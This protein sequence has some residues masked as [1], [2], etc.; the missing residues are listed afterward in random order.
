M[1]DIRRFTRSESSAP[2][3][4]VAGAAAVTSLFESPHPSP[5]RKPPLQERHD[6]GETTATVESSE[7]LAHCLA[8]GAQVHLNLNPAAGASRANTHDTTIVGWEAGG[9]IVLKRPQ[10]CTSFLGR[11]RRCSVRFLHGGEIWGFESRLAQDM[12]ALDQDL[13]ITLAWPH[14]AARYRLR[15][16]ERLQVNL[17]CAARYGAEAFERGVVEDVSPQGCGVVLRRALEPGEELQLAITIDFTQPVRWRRAVVRNRRS[18]DGSRFFCGCSF[19]DGSDSEEA[20]ELNNAIA[21]W[22]LSAHPGKGERHTVVILTPRP[23]GLKRSLGGFRL[24]G[25]EPILVS[26]P[27]ELGSCLSAGLPKAVLID[28]DPDNADAITLCRQLRHSPRF[29]LL[30]V[31]LFGGDAS[32]EAEALEAGAAV[33]T[34]S[35]NPAK[36]LEQIA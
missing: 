34:P 9:F 23:E 17:V 8:M 12:Q 20:Q 4:A 2:A 14:E 11:G 21:R 25:I 28:A 22:G 31:G 30:P 24:R 26:D 19:L 35:L 3:A 1:S 15:Q 13:T 33:W 36:L 27:V 10:K 16:A 7:S 6:T 32:V 18:L 5:E 29:G